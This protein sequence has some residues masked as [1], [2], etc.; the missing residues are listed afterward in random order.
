MTRR[1]SAPTLRSERSLGAEL[2]GRAPLSAVRRQSRFTSPHL[3]LA[4]ILVWLVSPSL[5]GCKGSAAPTPSGPSGNCPEGS[6]NSTGLDLG[7]DC[8]HN[9]DCCSGQCIGA[10]FPLIRDPS[11]ETRKL[12]PRCVAHCPSCAM[13]PSVDPDDTCT[14]TSGVSCKSGVSLHACCENGFWEECGGWD[15]ETCRGCLNGRIEAPQAG[16][17]CCHGV[18]LTE[19]S[20]RARLATVL[21]GSPVPIRFANCCQE[22]G[23]RPPPGEYLA[24][25]SVPD[26]STGTCSSGQVCCGGQP[27]PPTALV[28]KQC[29]N[30]DLKPTSDAFATCGD[31]GSGRCCNGNCLGPCPDGK[32]RGLPPGCECLDSGRTGIGGSTGSGGTAGSHG[33]GGSD[34]PGSSGG[35]RGSDGAGGSDGSVGPGGG[36]D[37]DASIAPGG[38][39]GSGDS[40][41]SDGGTG[42]GGEGGSD[43]A[44]GQGG[45][46]GGGGGGCAED[47]DCSSPA[48]QKC[49][50]GTC[51][52]QCT[53]SRTCC[54]NPGECV[55]LSTNF[56]NCGYCRNHLSSGQNCCGGRPVDIFNDPKN[57]GAQ[58]GVECADGVCCHGLCCGDGFACSQEKCCPTGKTNCKGECFDVK[59]DTAN[60][61]GCGIECSGG[62]ACA[63]GTCQCPVD[64]SSCGQACCKAEDTCF[65][66]ADATACCKAGQN[67]Y[68]DNKGSVVCC[69]APD[70]GCIG[71]DGSFS[72]CSF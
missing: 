69:T 16:E 15:P 60:C 57:C 11:G 28:C 48:C 4:F 29:K 68:A 70:H 32:K 72:C 51:I 71:L 59:S 46:G 6:R 31:R 14:N 62:K 40:G 52:D 33:S 10:E 64:T 23:S 63:A 44:A 12:K 37:V 7:E 18:I 8:Q 9:S 55:N 27:V 21:T 53:P 22:C 13:A 66:T 50:N 3:I 47:E 34:A 67:G 35:T 25:R 45:T 17:Q 19:N 58:C 20:D 61:G 65:F 43:G 49:I 39:G 56:F 30:G 1:R 26:G 36:G 24:L 5:Q 42:A 54:G 38:G 41:G 2:V